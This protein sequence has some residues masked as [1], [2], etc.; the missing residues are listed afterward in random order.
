[1]LQI[2]ETPEQGTLKLRKP[3][4]TIRLDRNVFNTLSEPAFFLAACVKP[5]DR[6]EKDK[7]ASDLSNC[8]TMVLLLAERCNIDL[9]LSIQL[10]IKLNARKYPVGIVKGSAL[11]YD[12]YHATT[13][14]GKGSKQV[15]TSK[16]C[17]GSASAD[18]RVAVLQYAG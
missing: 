13:G 10:K 7:V 2:E 1:M 4:I 11:K 6:S 17:C 15:N 14:Y 9:P 16:I 5:R 18:S 12:A 8:F 3:K